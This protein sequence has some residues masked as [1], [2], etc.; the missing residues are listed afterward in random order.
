MDKLKN[1]YEIAYHAKVRI[2]FLDKTT[3][4][5]MDIS[6]DTYITSYNEQWLSL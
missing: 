4:N 2:S 5:V 6:C 1:I 3:T